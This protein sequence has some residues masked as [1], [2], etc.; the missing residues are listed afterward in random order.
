V[1]SLKSGKNTVPRRETKYI[2]SNDI[3]MKMTSDL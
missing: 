1:I 2:F 3:V